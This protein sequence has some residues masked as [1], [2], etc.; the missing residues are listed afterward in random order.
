MV[1]TLHLDYRYLTATD[2][3]LDALLLGEAVDTRL[4]ADFLAPE[5][6]RVGETGVL[7]AVR[8]NSDEPRR[9][10]AL[11][12]RD[13]DVRRLCG[14][15]AQ[16]R[17][18]L[19]PLTAWCH[20]LTPS[21]LRS[22]DGIVHEP[23]FKGTEAAWSGLVVAETMLLTGK[24]LASIR[25]SACLASAT[26]AVGRTKALW[27]DLPIDAIVE[28]FYVANRLCRGRN[29]SQRNQPRTSRVRS[30]FVPMWNCLSA[31]TA[32]SAMA[33][34]EDLQPL[35]MALEELREAR[36][37]GDS[38]EAGLL[39]RPLL[40]AVPE[41]RALGQLAK[42]APESRLKL[43]DELVGTFRRS[44][45]E[46]LLRY[47]ALAF[48]VGYL[49][50]V[51]A[52]GAASLALVDHYAEEWPAL[53]GWA[54]LVGSIGERITWTSGFDG[55][56]RLI[57]RELQRGLRLDEPPMCDFALDEAV[58]LSDAQL[59]D[60]LVYLKIKQARVLNVA[61]Y[62][63]VNIAVPIVEAVAQESTHQSHWAPRPAV[64]GEVPAGAAISLEALA[65][66][67]WPF[68]RPL[69][70]E[71]TAQGSTFE[72]RGG[73]GRGKKKGAVHSRLPLG[74]PKK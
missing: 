16:L 68:I 3:E 27:R 18:D 22:L 70:I 49:A 14:R 62:P 26:Y 55:L 38:D 42:M 21:L 63:G 61:L 59:R 67:L 44:D 43:F 72:D 6:L 31:L 58:V 40:A 24:P 47:N 54:Y 52:G 51:A 64:S 48:I 36:S 11:V 34:Q 13:E 29:G 12:A 37:C 56:G 28:R 45:A 17:A 9:P 20:L 15:Y 1:S 2:S 60:P 33:G 8:T 74:G 19:S 53:T 41:A 50:T 4:G 46:A 30:S 71:E 23:R 65:A 32:D 10:L 73:K 5:P 69:V 25:I 66:V 57:A 39:V 35:I 7:V